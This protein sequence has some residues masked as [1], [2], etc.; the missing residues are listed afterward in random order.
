MAPLVV[1][2]TDRATV[3]VTADTREDRAMQVTTTTV[4][5][6]VTLAVSGMID[7]S[8]RKALGTLIEGRMAHGQ[9]DFILN[10]QQ[11]AFMDSSGL[12]ALVAC[13]SS[14]R[15]QGGSMKL[16]QLPRQVLELIT[17]TNLTHFF[18][19]CDTAEAPVCNV[20]V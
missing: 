10:L 9:R 17:R 8:A 13:F 19:L 5:Q 16:T 14:I 2:G 4:G 1:D 18:D 7:F 6:T 20:S 11:V 3:R 12:G 15:K